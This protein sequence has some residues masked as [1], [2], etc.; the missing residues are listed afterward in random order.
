MEITI[1]IVITPYTGPTSTIDTGGAG[2]IRKRAIAVVLI[3]RGS[4]NLATL[5]ALGYEYK[6]A[7]RGF[8]PGADRRLLGLRG[9]RPPSHQTKRHG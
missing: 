3:E 9:V 8:L 5:F 7:S 2:H 6:P 1:V 4:G